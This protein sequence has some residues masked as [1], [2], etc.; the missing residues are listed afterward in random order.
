MALNPLELIYQRREDVLRHLKLSGKCIS[1]HTLTFYMS[2]EFWVT[3]RD[4]AREENYHNEV[5]Y[6]SETGR[7][8]IVGCEAYIVP[9]DLHPYLVIH[10]TVDTSI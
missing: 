6:C 2:V 9:S 10:T 1:D 3:L 5:S 8:T 7:I 4:F